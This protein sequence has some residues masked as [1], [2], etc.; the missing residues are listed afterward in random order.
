MIDLFDL[1][2]KLLVKDP[3]K[4]LGG[5]LKD[6]KYSISELK[7]H[8]FF[9]KLNFEDLKRRIPQ[10][11]KCKNGYNFIKIKEKFDKLEFSE[12]QVFTSTK[13]PFPDSLES[14]SS[15]SSKE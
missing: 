8:P 14:D 15:T 7:K 6:S 4:R 11:Q 5:G 1:I 3:L 13:I 10:I 12:K 2:K 9:E